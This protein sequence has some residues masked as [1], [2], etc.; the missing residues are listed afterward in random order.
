MNQEVMLRPIVAAYRY[1]VAPMMDWTDRHCRYFHRLISRRAL[2]YTEMVSAQA[3]LRGT[4]DTLLAYDPTENPLALQIGGSNPRE[5]ADA[6]RLCAGRGFV[7]I[8]LNAGCPSDRVQDGCFGA[9]LMKDPVRTA[10]CLSALKEGSGGTEVTLKCRI[11]VDEQEPDQS[12]PDFIATV[13]K[14]GIE[15]ISIHARKAE[16]QHTAIRLPTCFA[17]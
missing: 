7:E 9:I 17:N 12:L 10:D 5:L 6:A 8:N 1:S 16:S 4:L 13:S 11:G 3:I 15:R 2:L 14:S